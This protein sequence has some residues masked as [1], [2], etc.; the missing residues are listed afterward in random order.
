VSEP[1]EDP[2]PK[3]LR[4]SRERGQIPSSRDAIAAA[5]LLGGVGALVATGSGFVDTF[6]SL[7]IPA[8]RVARGEVAAH[9]TEATVNAAAAVA[10]VS[11]PVLASAAGGAVLVGALLSGFLF[12]P[13]AALPQLDRL[14]PLKALAKYVRLRT[15]VEPLIQL[16]KGLGLLALGWTVARASMSAWLLAP[17]GGTSGFV[18]AL[19]ETLPSIAFRM[20]AALAAVA[21]LDVLYRRWQH[22]RDM[23]MTKEDVKREH[24]ESDGDP[25]AK[26]ARERVHR[27]MLAEATLHR[28][29]KASFVVTNPTHYAVAL[30]W[31]EENMEAPAVVARG[32]GLF[33][34]RI[35]AEA[36]RAGVA[37]L[38]D[39][40]LARSLH[41]LEIGDEVP[42]VLFES[43]A[44][45]VNYLAAGRDPDRYETP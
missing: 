9:P 11:L 33:A 38:R 2:T 8:F 5:A 17:R 44:A 19:R 43:V 35:I 39:A 14:D 42:E 36:Q 28:V 18:R 41:D 31:D 22:T 34:Q 6:R 32:E 21:L 16:L 26:S 15:Y 29:Q 27:E 45:V 23:R 7:M 1:T 13:A 12:A 40:P 10:R 24:R 25:H 37:V 30:E 3:R 4:Q 20:L